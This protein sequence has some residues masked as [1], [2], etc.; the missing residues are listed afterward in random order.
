M[1]YLRQICRDGK[2]CFQ[3]RRSPGS[4]WLETRTLKADVEIMSF[5][6]DLENVV[7]YTLWPAWLIIVAWNE[8]RFG[9]SEIVYWLN[10]QWQW[11]SDSIL[12]KEYST[13][14]ANIAIYSKSILDYRISFIS[15]TNPFCF[16]FPYLYTTVLPSQPNLKI[17]YTS[18]GIHEIL[19]KS[20]ST[21][22]R[23][24]ISSVHIPPPVGPIWGQCT[25][26]LNGTMFWCSI[27]HIKVFLPNS[28]SAPQRT[29]VVRNS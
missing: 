25:E 6:F 5:D 18:L 1:E 13:Y 14:Q 4:H 24:V 11:I 7:P 27:R 26:G 17:C 8:W 23:Y 28:Y 21:V 15:V 12:A 2:P 20:C 16:G 22:V 9:K 19:K 3:I 29:S 10:F